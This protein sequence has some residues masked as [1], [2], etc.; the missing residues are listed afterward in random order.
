MT[1]ASANASAI[2]SA[3]ASP[4]RS[5]PPGAPSIS[6]TPASAIASASAVRRPIGSPS[7]TRASSAAS[8]GEIAWTNSTR[9]TVVWFSA[10]MN[11]PEAVAR[12]SARPTPAIPIERQASRKRPRSAIATNSSS[13][14]AAKTA[15][16]ATCV[17]TSSESCRWSTP[18]VDHATAASAT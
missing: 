16:P 8:T 12:Q 9:A 4:A 15:R 6:V 1:S 5:P 14:N 2:S 10:A 11:A 17:A 18:A 3:S 13:A 7:S